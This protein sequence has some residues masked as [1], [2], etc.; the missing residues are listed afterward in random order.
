MM[1]F[2]GVLLV[3]TCIG[4]DAAVAD[5][6]LLRRNKIVTHGPVLLQRTERI[7]KFLPYHEFYHNNNIPRGESGEKPKEMW[8][9]PKVVWVILADVLAMTI[10]LACIP[11]VL[12]LAKQSKRIEPT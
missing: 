8:G 12:S 5:H 10:F 6:G 2:L 3:L 7:D 4:G 9:M 1:R 11:I